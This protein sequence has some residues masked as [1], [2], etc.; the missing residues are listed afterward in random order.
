MAFGPDGHLYVSSFPEKAIFR[1]DGATGVFIDI[2]ADLS[3]LS[4]PGPT[5]P[6]NVVF[7]PDGNLYTDVRYPGPLGA[8][9][10]FDGTTGEYIDRWIEPGSGGLQI[11][12]K[13]FLFLDS[14]CSRY[15]DGGFGNRCF[16]PNALTV[17]IDITPGSDPNCFNANGHGVI[18]VTI[19]GSDSFDVTTIDPSTLLFGGLEVRVRGNKGPLCSLDDSNVDG[20][21]DLVC[22]F[23]D[24]A[25][26]WDPGNG[27]A[28]LTGNLYDGTEFKGTDSICVVP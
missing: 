19:L 2:F 25:D 6:I 18:P 3:G 15:S 13:A 17:E 24:N 20:L 5:F 1:F 28:T 26:Y 12:P 4:D 27:D 16:I 10:R 21:L 7:G 22:K 8:V 9:V 14:G 11:T 23:E